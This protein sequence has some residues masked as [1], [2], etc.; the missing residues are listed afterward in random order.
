MGRIIARSLTVLLPLSQL[1]AALTVQPEAA[2]RVSV[3]TLTST[4]TDTVTRTITSLSA[5]TT[6]TTCATQSYADPFCTLD[7]AWSLVGNWF[8]QWCSGV[9]LE[10]GTT[11]T[12][13]NYASLYECELICWQL[14]TEC[15]G[16]NY[17]TAI[18]AC[19]LLTGSLTAT[20]AASYRAAMRFTTNPC[21]VTETSI[22]TGLMTQTSTIVSVVTYTS[23]ITMPDI[24][25]TQTGSVSVM[26][27]STSYANFHISSRS[28]QFYPRNFQHSGH[29]PGNHYSLLSLA[30]VSASI[31]DS[32]SFTTSEKSSMPNQPSAAASSSIAIQLSSSHSPSSSDTLTLTP[33]SRLAM[34]TT[35]RPAIT[36]SSA[37]S[38]HPSPWVSLQSSSQNIASTTSIHAS[39]SPESTKL[40]QAS[41]S[42]PYMPSFTNQSTNLPSH[43]TPPQP[44]ISTYN[45][46]LPESASSH[47]G[48]STTFTILTT[49]V[50]T[51]TSCPDQVTDCPNTDKT[52]FL[53]TETI[54]VGTTIYPVTAVM[55]SPTIL[56]PAED[57]YTEVSTVYFTNIV[58][59]SAC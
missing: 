4:Y 5:S 7:G 3:E 31:V 59:I 30:S 54:T 18:R 15:N 37:L 1:T 32:S 35:S 25:S 58:T 50:H 24:L 16:V 33:S 34:S 20:S 22:S 57:V 12:S 19:Y 39:S 10:G 51:V 21:T 17:N 47:G 46:S 40:P 14:S 13:A 38:L 27:T 6:T 9:S 45:S 44:A 53:T 29:L 43:L 11:V 52:T 28:I 41:T 26:P 49:Q 23:T 42:V 55:A 56:Q 8:Q 48:H 2:A 36:S